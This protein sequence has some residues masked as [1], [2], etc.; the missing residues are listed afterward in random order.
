MDS[1]KGQ[2]STLDLVASIFIFMVIVS[3]FLW[4]WG[5]TQTQMWSYEADRSERQEALGIMEILTR[6]GGMPDG[7]EL[8]PNVTGGNVTSIGLASEP[9]VLSVEKLRRLSDIPYEDARG[10]MGLGG[11]GFSLKIVNSYNRTVYEF[12]E[13]HG[14]GTIIER[15]VVLSGSPARIILSVF[16]RN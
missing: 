5:E 14:A 11:K 2:L 15:P 8:L 13:E 16:D 9:V 3:M 6:T 12:G 4:A 7:W 10:I 1:H